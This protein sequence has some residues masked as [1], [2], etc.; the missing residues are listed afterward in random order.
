VRL[1]LA[2]CL[3]LSS[4]CTINLVRK[5]AQP[6]VVKLQLDYWK[7]LYEH[8]YQ[9]TDPDLMRRAAARLLDVK[10]GEKEGEPGKQIDVLEQVLKRLEDEIERLS[11]EKQ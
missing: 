6:E 1:A 10:L 7:F 8:G 11:K 4:G 2:L 5:S 3:S 9:R